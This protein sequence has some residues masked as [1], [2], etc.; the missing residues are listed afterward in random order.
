MNNSVLMKTSVEKDLG[1][2]VSDDLEWHHHVNIAIGNANRK[3][4]LIKN[5]DRK[6]FIISIILNFKLLFCFFIFK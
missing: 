2:Y 5:L 4:G 6:P 1:I 3:L